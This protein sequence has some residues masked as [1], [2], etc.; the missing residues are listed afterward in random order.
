MLHIFRG[1]KTID[2][3]GT[4]INFGSSQ[5]ASIARS[6][7]AQ[8]HEAPIVVGHPIDNAPAYGWIDRLESRGLDLYAIPKQVNS[9]FKKL[10]QQGAYKKISSSFYL[11]DSPHNPKPGSYYLRHVGFLGA[12][13]PA[14]KG[15]INPA[16]SEAE[17]CLILNFEEAN[18]YDD[19]KSALAAILDS[20]A[21]A[22]PDAIP[23]DQIDALMMA[24]D[25]LAEEEAAEP[26]TKAEDPAYSERF[27]ALVL[28]E[29]AIELAGKKAVANTI[30]SFCDQMCKTGQM[31]A[32][33]RPG[34]T[35]LLTLAAMASADYS[36]GGKSALDLAMASYSNRSPVVPMGE[37][38]RDVP[39]QNAIVS[40]S[41]GSI[42]SVQLVAEARKL[43]AAN[44]TL[45]LSEAMESIV[46]Q[47][48]VA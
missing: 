13:P 9:A 7:N 39:K 8:L 27:A 16:F 25:G 34:A 19:L 21:V 33:E 1:G 44:P 12:M 46:S 35:K 23:A 3:N 11:P 28:R 29:K 48:E 10:V 14:I 38:S 45:D 43:V 4:R 18:M 22:M 5:I 20:V 47:L 6:Y 26:T 37:R 17:N 24:I 42:D 36:D 15:L 30:A 32:G 2:S 31:T 40:F 41:D